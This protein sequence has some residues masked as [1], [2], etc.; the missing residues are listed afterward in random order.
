MV[1]ADHGRRRSLLL[2]PG[3]RL[4][5]HLQVP[6]GVLQDEGEY[7]TLDLSE[8]DEGGLT[9]RQFIKIT[10]LNTGL[11][12]TLDESNSANVRQKLDNK[13]LLL[14]GRKRIKQGPGAQGAA[15]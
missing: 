4:S 1:Q 7:F 5:Y 6:E 2:P 14:Y 11:N 10:Q 8:L 13:R 9:L 12:F 15:R 3:S